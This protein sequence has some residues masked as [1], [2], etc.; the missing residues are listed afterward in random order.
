MQ[1]RGITYRPL[2]LRVSP[3]R[4]AVDAGRPRK[5]TLI[6]ESQHAVADVGHSGV[7]VIAGEGCGAVAGTGVIQVAG[8]GSAKRRGTCI[9]HGQSRRRPAAVGDDARGTWKRGGAVDAGKRL[10]PA[11]EI[12]SAAAIDPHRLKRRDGIGRKDRQGVVPAAVQ[13]EQAVVDRGLA[14]VGRRTAAC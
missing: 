2:S 14:V 11:V 1:A 8:D 10:A 4:V 3:P 13:R 9:S 12:K 5:P 7:G 6:L